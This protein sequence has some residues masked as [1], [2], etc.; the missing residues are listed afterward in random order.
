MTEYPSVPKLMRTM[1]SD[2]WVNAFS[3]FFDLNGIDGGLM[4]CCGGET[5]LY[6][7]IEEVMEFVYKRGFA[8]HVTTNLSRDMSGLK[9]ISISSVRITAS[10]H[11]T[12]P[13]FDWDVFKDKVVDLKNAGYAIAV[14]IVSHPDNIPLIPKY[15]DF[16]QQHG[17]NLCVVPMTGG[18]SG[19]EFND[20]D[21][22]PPHLRD[23]LEKYVN[24]DHL[25]HI[26]EVI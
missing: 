22:Y 13:H 17:V 23:I 7:G 11:H 24:P 8:L 20:I 16:L 5:M 2:A 3:R 12:E 14:N 21:D 19:V 18:W 9:R 4:Q 15:Y 25:V 6:E 10:L 1:S 26:T